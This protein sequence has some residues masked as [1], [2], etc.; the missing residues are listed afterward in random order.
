MPG[1]GKINMDM[2]KPLSQV[3]APFH[4]WNFLR[5]T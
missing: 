1:R 4:S 5:G 2:E 3:T